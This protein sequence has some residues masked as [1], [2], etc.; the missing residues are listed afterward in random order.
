MATPNERENRIGQAPAVVPGSSQDPFYGSTG[1]YKW[2]T[3]PNGQKVFAL[4]VGSTKPPAAGGVGSISP[5]TGLEISGTER[6]M[7]KEREAMK[8]GYTKEYIASRGGIN[9]QGYFNDTPLNRQLTADEYKSV[10]KPDGTIDTQAMLAILNAKGADK[11]LDLGGGGTGV[12]SGIGTGIGGTSS[13][14][15][16]TTGA[17][18]S[19]GTTEAQKSARSAYDL[20]FEQFNQYGLGSLIEPL[21]GFIIEGISPAEFAIRLRDTKAYQNRF[22][23]NKQRVQNGLRALSESEY[24]KTEDAYQEIMRRYGLPADYY[25]QTVDPE[26]GVKIQKGFEQLIAGDVSSMELEDRIATA[27]N[28]IINGAPQVMASLRQFFP[29][30]TNGDVLAYVLDPVNSIGN[31]K[32]KVAISEIGASAFENA[33]KMDVTR[34]SELQKYGITGEAYRQ[35]APT[36]KQTATTGGQLAEIYKQT[37]FTQATAEAAALGVGDTASAIEQINRLSGLQRASFS[38]KAGA[39]GGALA[40]DRAGSF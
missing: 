5:A 4:D 39:A 10:T 14:G 8:I 21:K 7:A 31:I 2:V 33:L 19:V 9:S 12:G 24:I 29:E 11:P 23:A 25:T 36:I 35:Q 26:T 40:R 13:T 28:R 27:Q 32:R 1:Q 15:G 17:V 34:A 6:N 37:P 22:A 18:G 16:G 38:G 30:V 3:L 20:L